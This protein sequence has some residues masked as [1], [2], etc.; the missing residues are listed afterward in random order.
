MASH[1]PGGRRHHMEHRT[2][3]LGPQVGAEHGVEATGVAEPHPGHVQYQLPRRRHGVPRA[4]HRRVQ[5]PTGVLVQLPH[6][7]QHRICAI[8]NFSARSDQPLMKHVKITV[9]RAAG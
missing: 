9:S 1:H 7:L 6:R 5:K 8:G 3:C 2:C 4:V